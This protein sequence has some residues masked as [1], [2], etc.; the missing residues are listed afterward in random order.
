MSVNQI[1]SIGRSPT[2]DYR[3]SSSSVSTDHAMLIVSDGQDP[4]FLLI[5][6]ESSNGT[7]VVSNDGL[8]EIS[9]MTVDRNTEIF[10]GDVSCRAG[11]VVAKATAASKSL[12]SSGQDTMKR[13]PISGRIETRPKT[14]VSVDQATVDK[15]NGR[16]REESRATSSR[17]R[18]LSFVAAMALFL[19]NYFNFEGRSSRSGYWYPTLALTFG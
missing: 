5:D 14:A 18:N 2:S 11:D 10:F 9:Q 6:K 13:D 15:K 8:V 17:A 19:E 7:R 4:S 12:G 16:A 1:I 3:L